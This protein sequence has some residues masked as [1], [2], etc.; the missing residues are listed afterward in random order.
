MVDGHVQLRYGREI[1]LG[2]LKYD[3]ID[4]SHQK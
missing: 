2:N 3:L 1:G 4:V